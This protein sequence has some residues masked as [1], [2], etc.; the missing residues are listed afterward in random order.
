MNKELEARLRKELTQYK[1]RIDE[2]YDPVDKVETVGEF[3]KY[4]MEMNKVHEIVLATPMLYEDL[5]DFHK[6]KY[7]D[8]TIDEKISWYQPGSPNFYWYEPKWLSN[9]S[10]FYDCL[11]LEKY[12]RRGTYEPDELIMIV[13]IGIIDGI[14]KYTSQTAPNEG[15]IEPETGWLKMANI[16]DY[17]RWLKI[18]DA[19]ISIPDVMTHSETYKELHSLR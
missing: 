17:E 15:N 18:A 7:A 12:N 4:V 10:E 11:T 6:P 13:R 14:V 9:T 1:K 8:Y 19:I 16:L 3:L 2:I 5:K